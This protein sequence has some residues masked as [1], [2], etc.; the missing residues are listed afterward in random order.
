M[1]DLKET[2]AI[3]V[4]RMRHDRRWTQEDHAHHIGISARY[5]GQIERAQASMTISI[6]GRIA[7]AFNVEASELVERSRRRH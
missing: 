6:L 4:R 2:V 1:A 5:I 7:N 3:N